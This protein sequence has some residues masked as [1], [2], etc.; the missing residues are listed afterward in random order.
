MNPR[1]P[2][3]IRLRVLA[4]LLLV[5]GLCIGLLIVVTTTVATMVAEQIVNDSNPKAWSFFVPRE[6]GA[7]IAAVVIAVSALVW[8]LLM[9]LAAKIQSSYHGRH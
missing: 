1:N 3:S 2:A 9:G 6:P 4:W 8:L 7:S 5:V